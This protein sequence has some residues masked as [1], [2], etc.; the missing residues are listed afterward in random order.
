MDFERIARKASGSLAGLLNTAARRAADDDCPCG[1]GMKTMP[2]RSRRANCGEEVTAAEGCGEPG[3]T[4]AA[5]EEV[6]ENMTEQ[7]PEHG[8]ANDAHSGR[9]DEDGPFAFKVASRSPFAE[10]DYAEGWLS[11]THRRTGK[12]YTLAGI[13]RQAARAFVDHNA[14]GNGHQAMAVVQADARRHR[15]LERSAFRLHSQHR[16]V[17]FPR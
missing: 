13:T 2:R 17:D 6:V 11:F 12:R 15:S 16:T 8:E 5:G 3:P 4:V 7:F 9:A 10:I 1:E 14:A